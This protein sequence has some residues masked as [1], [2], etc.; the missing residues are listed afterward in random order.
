MKTMV[1]VSLGIVYIIL[2]SFIILYEKLSRNYPGEN[3]EAY[4]YVWFDEK[5]EKI[6]NILGIFER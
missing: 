1:I 2:I 3:L 6:K 4:I 5:V